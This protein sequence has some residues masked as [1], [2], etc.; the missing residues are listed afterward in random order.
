VAGRIRSTEKSN[1][2]IGNRTRDLPACGI[3]LQPT[4]IPRA[5]IIIMIIIT[6]SLIQEI[7]AKETNK[8]NQKL[9]TDIKANNTAKKKTIINGKTL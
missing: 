7:T 6:I 3:V 1:D 5:I 9:L 4:I 2:L 8:I